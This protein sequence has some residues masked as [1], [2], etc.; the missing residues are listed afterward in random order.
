[1]FVASTLSTIE[2]VIPYVILAVVVVFFL[3]RLVVMPLIEFMI[4]ARHRD[5]QRA[6]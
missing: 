2:A 4:R 6:E 3:L 1:M 5:N